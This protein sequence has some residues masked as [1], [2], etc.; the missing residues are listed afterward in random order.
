MTLTPVTS[1]N[2]AAIGHDP[3]T[4]DLT[5]AFKNG[6][7]YTYADVP[8]D[9]HADLMA[10]PSVGQ[11][12]NRNIKDKYKATKSGAPV[13]PPADTTHLTLAA[14]VAQLDDHKSTLYRTDAQLPDGR[15]VSIVVGLGDVGRFVSQEARAW[16]TGTEKAFYP[17][18]VT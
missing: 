3:I 14:I 15:F 5:V 4:H 12:F 16:A 9:T 7:E 6:T 17:A 1:S 18:E 13:P 11:Y 2:I 8:L 10:A